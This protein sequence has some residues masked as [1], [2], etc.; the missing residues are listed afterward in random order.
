MVLPLSSFSWL[1]YQEM[2][3]LAGESSTKPGYELSPP[4]GSSANSWS[5]SPMSQQR[6]VFAPFFLRGV[7]SGDEDVRA[8]LRDERAA[9]GAVE[10]LPIPFGEGWFGA[11]EKRF[12]AT[13]M[14]TDGEEAAVVLK[15]KGGFIA[16]GLGEVG[17]LL[18]D[19]AVIA[20]EHEGLHFFALAF[21]CDVETGLASATEEGFAAV[22]G[23]AP[24][25]VAEGA[26]QHRRFAPLG[27]IGR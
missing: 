11:N 12:L 16:R 8:P 13:T 9:D 17:T 24:D 7:P 6:E 4:L 19:E 14:A 21:C 5:V 18:P 22:R 26:L 10:R 25:V 1:E 3:P 23:C 2:R 27:A 15:K 20:F